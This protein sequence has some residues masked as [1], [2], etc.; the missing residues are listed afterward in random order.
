M[1]INSEPIPINEPM[2]TAK[3]DPGASE[4][5]KALFKRIK[6]FLSDSWVRYMQNQTDLINASPSRLPPIELADQ[7]A[8]IGTTSLVGDVGAGL[9]RITYYARISLPSGGT[10]SLTVSFAW[11][12][13]GVSPS[14]SGSAITGNLT[15]TIQTGTLSVR[16]DQA[17]PMTYSTTYASTGSPAMQYELD[18][19]VERIAA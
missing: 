15:T 19:Y 2:V 18:I 9:Y 8:S 3:L 13:G 5:V 7:A 16:I 10:S 14:I 1:A 12:D 6:F 17:S 11:T 4:N